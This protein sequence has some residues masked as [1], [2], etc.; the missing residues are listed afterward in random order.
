MN[1]A[2]HIPHRVTEVDS[3]ALSLAQRAPTFTIEWTN[4]ER[5]TIARFPS[6]PER[7]DCA[8]QLVGE[9]IRFHGAWASVNARPVS[10]L[11]KLWQRLECYRGSL[12]APEPDRHCAER[13]ALVNSLV[14]CEAHRCPVPCQFMCSPCIGMGQNGPMMYPEKRLELAAAVAEIDWCPRLKLPIQLGPV[15]V[16]RVNPGPATD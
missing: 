12:L 3:S 16:P 11:T 6:L 4:G 2:V 5:V 10:S 13:A 8:L 7:L 9:A 14:G 15:Q 1:L